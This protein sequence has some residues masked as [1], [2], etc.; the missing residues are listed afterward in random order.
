MANLLSQLGARIDTW[1]GAAKMRRFRRGWPATATENVRFYKTSMVQYRYLEEGVGPTIV[2][3]VDP[4][5]TI[6]VYGPLVQAFYSQFRVIVVELPAMGFSATLGGYGFGFEETN[7][8]LASFLRTICGERSIFAFSCAASLA[9]IDLAYRMPELVSHLCLIQAG[10]TEAFAIWKAARDPKGILAKPVIGQ[11]VMKRM[12]PR[13]MP[14]WYGLSV[15]RTEQIE[16]FCTCAERSFSQGAMWSLASA[17]QL[18][19]D[20]RHELPQPSQ[21]MLSIWGGAD[22]SHPASNAHSLARLYSGVESVTF[23]HLG[24]TPELEEPDRVL[25]A[26]TAFLAQS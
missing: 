23:D 25:D 18:Y 8:D 15:G 7:D 3:T 17:Y 20:Q 12:A 14:Q 22:R 13:R 21:P 6:E 9:A 11:L 5:M 2:F 19:L 16:H 10:G 24:H 1:N 4:P 26:I